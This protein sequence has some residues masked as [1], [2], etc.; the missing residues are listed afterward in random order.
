MYNLTQALS[1][2]VLRGQDFNSV[3]QNAP[4]ILEKS[5]ITWGNL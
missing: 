2:G 5:L 3:M 1:A 4:L